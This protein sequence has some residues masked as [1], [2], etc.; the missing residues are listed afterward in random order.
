M[1]TLV[2][3]L[4][5]SAAFLQA[6]PADTVF[7]AK[8]KVEA[9]RLT[10]PITIDGVLAEPVWQNGSGISQFTQRDPTEG[11]QPTQK[12]IVHLAYDDEAIYIGARLFDTAPDSIIAR[13]GRRDASLTSDMFGFFID[14]YHDRRSGF[15]FSLNAAGTMYDGV[16]FND[17]WDDD[18][19]DGVW[20]G[21]AKIDAHGWSAEMRIPYSQLRF[22]K[23]D[24][25]VWGI[26]FRRDIARKNERDYLVF[27]PK[28]GSGFVS[29]FVDL[30]GIENIS[31]PRRIEVLPYVTTK[32]EYMQHAPGNPFNDG[33][34]YLPGTG[35]DLKVGIGSNLTLDAT[36]NP[37]F[38]QVEVDP[39]VVNLG[40]V[41]TFFNEKRPFFIEG[42]TIF[43]FGQGGSR[44]NWGFNWANPQFFYTRRIGRAPQGSLPSA[45]FV[46][47]PLGT[48]ILGAA[49]LTGKVGNNWNVG[50]LHALTSRESAELKQDNRRWRSEVEPLTYYGIMRAQKE[51]KEGRQGIGF[52]STLAAR[53]FDETRL[54]DEIN[55]SAFAGGVDGWTFLDASKTWVITGW[56]GM[57][58]LRGNETRMIA[59]QQSSRHYFQRPDAGH[60]SVDSSA[61]SLTGYAGRLLLNKQKGNIIFNSALGFV[62]PKFD[63][64]DMGFLWRTDVI[65][66]HV[67]GGYKWTKTN[68][69]T[70]YAE[71]LGAVFGSRDFDGNTIWFGVWQSGSFEFLNYY[72]FN[73]SFAYNPA[74]VSNNRTRGGPLTLNRPG[75]EVNF[76]VNSDSRKSWV[77]GLG[78][79]GYS[80][81]PKN[82][83]RGLEA[84]AEWKPGANLSISAGP[85]LWW[86]RDFSQYVTVSDDP[87]AAA[88]FGKRYIFGELRQTELSASFRMNWTFTPRLSLQLY[89]QPLISSGDY[90]NFKELARAKSYA[91][92]RF[93]DGA[94]TITFTEGTYRADPD[95]DTGAAP[96]ISFDNPD[97]N[98][99]SLR[100]NAVLRWEYS[101]G[102]TLYFVWTQS[103]SD[104]EN[105]GDFQFNRSVNRLGDT[106][107]DNIFLIKASYWWGL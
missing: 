50:M 23:K 91:F 26:N 12:T 37:D 71:L 35:A 25:L 82:W 5:L 105:F 60:V 64:N 44:S 22:K 93:G 40:D 74:T 52:I 69:V 66:G 96:A 102:S 19:W 100:G 2:A 4:L 8:L 13:L 3:V 45:D 20:E 67:G 73:Y 30:V 87:L 99:K 59:L 56:A 107:P 103:R 10:A 92:N 94:S 62:D 83:D 104:Y 90:N 89:A 65:N 41:E 53:R 32:A 38:G 79:F 43:N 70:R 54:R 72:N 85:T 9:I 84:S 28:N 88:T 24:Q 18:S 97:F 21:K 76:F 34:K 48:S 33:S 68:R 17:E 58:Q 98:F 75:W 27:T 46:D 63:L 16:L 57:S 11:A 29:R 95:G 42:S 1:K 39:A 15:Y 55:S 81:G 86:N 51:I 80:R 106:R 36:V 7:T 47:A 61:T 31:P 101:P 78:T 14:P 77:F 6:A 49:K